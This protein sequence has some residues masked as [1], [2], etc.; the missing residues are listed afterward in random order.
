MKEG[1]TDWLRLRWR[2]CFLRVVSDT[3]RLIPDVLRPGPGASGGADILSTD[4]S[5]LSSSSVSSSQLSSPRMT[6]G[7]YIIIII[8]WTHRSRPFTKD[9]SKQRIFSYMLY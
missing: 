5:D 8:I 3:E 1:S 4:L 9:S 6:S 2:A 7:S